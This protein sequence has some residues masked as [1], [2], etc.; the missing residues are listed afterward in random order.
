MG[1][2][3]YR[4]VMYFNLKRH[5]T[6][7]ITYKDD[8]QIPKGKIKDGKIVNTNVSFTKPYKL[9]I[10]ASK[11]I[12]GKKTIKK[13]TLTYPTTTTL[14][15]AIDNATQIYKN[16]MTDIE[17]NMTIE[18][19][20]LNAGMKFSDAF[21]SYVKH[22]ELEYKNNSSKTDYNSKG[23]YAFFNK[24]LKA[25]HNKPLNQI[26]PKDI[27]A[28]KSNMIGKSDRYKLAVHQWINPVYIFINDNID[29]YVKS[30]A[31]IKKADRNFNN[32]RSLTLS[33][34]EIKN[35]FK[36]LRDYPI[37]PY[38]EVFMWLMHGRRRNEVLSLQWSDI[39]LKNNT[40][41]IRSVN[42]KARCDMTYKLT[43]R[44]RNTL[45][46][47]AGLNTVDGMSGNVFRGVRDNTKPLH[48]LRM[49]K[50]WLDLELPIV[51]HQLRACIV[52]YLK[53]VHNVTNEMSGYIL[54]H[55]Q[56]SSVTERYGTFGYEVLSDNLNLMLDDVFDDVKPIDNKLQK[57]QALFPDKTREQ[58]EVFLND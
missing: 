40:Y 36:Q 47:Q 21:T 17:N 18:N 2:N 57:L 5:T 27:T 7:G 42:N 20:E 48:E 22:K 9:Q 28:L 14:L 53:N 44:L 46:V 10:R 37:S 25:I 35:L 43:D 4:D 41:M 51:M 15:D 34:D 33:N 54:G 32:T 6:A 26:R 1:I 52:S 49:R 39:D 8:G 24:Y 3:Y 45:E 29:S 19:T 23:A 58:L 11:M 16:M 38:R 30:P 55:I 12:E 50:H 31:K 13:K 56:S